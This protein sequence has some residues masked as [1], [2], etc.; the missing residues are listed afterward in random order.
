MS[1]NATGGWFVVADL[2]GG[3]DQC[4]VDATFA[5]GA[6]DATYCVKVTASNGFP[7]CDESDEASVTVPA[8]VAVSLDVSGEEACNNGV[9]TFTATA[10][11]GV[12]PYTYTFKE[13]GNVVQGPGASNSW[14]RGIKLDGNG[15]DTACHTVSVEAQDSRGCPGAPA[16]DFITLSQCVNTTLGCDAA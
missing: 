8:Q 14:G 12:G 5:P 16:S 13:D 9:L 10:S 2:G 3:L 11:G 6:S 1:E 4:S 15:L 7:T